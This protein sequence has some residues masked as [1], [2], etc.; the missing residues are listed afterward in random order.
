MKQIQR[1]APDPPFADFWSVIVLC[2]AAIAIYL[3][4]T[5]C[6]GGL[7]RMIVSYTRQ[8]GLAKVWLRSRK[9][10]E[11]A[12]SRKTRTHVGGQTDWQAQSA[13]PKSARLKSPRLKSAGALKPGKRKVCKFQ[14]GMAGLK[15]QLSRRTRSDTRGCSTRPRK[16][17]TPD[18]DSRHP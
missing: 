8:P 7:R 17:W 9:G 1:P 2:L 3:W 13:R 10:H 6:R 16:R 4:S 5:T 14:I 15:S 18:R 11:R 12:K